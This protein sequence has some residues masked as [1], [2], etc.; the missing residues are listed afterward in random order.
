[1]NGTKPEEMMKKAAGV[2]L[3]RAA[4]PLFVSVL[5][6]T[7]AATQLAK[8]LI[9]SQVKTYPVDISELIM[10]HRLNIEAVIS[11][12]SGLKNPPKRTTMA[13]SK[14]LIKTAG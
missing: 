10:A 1:M 14:R 8:T 13:K 4:K 6:N 12:K 9:M 5:L 11:S 2:K 7:I 3:D